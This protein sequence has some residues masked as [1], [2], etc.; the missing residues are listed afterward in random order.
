MELPFV[1]KYQPI[2]LKDFEIEEELKSL[3]NTLINM[4]ALNLLFVGGFC[5]LWMGRITL[6]LSWMN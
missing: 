5:N 1:Y 3:I 4:D 2:F 6:I